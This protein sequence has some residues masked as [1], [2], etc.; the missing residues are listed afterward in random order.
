MRIRVPDAVRT[1]TELDV[2]GPLYRKAEV[3]SGGAQS[4]IFTRI[5]EPTPGRLRA[6]DVQLSGELSAHISVVEN[7]TFDGTNRALLMGQ[8]VHASSVIEFN[9]A[10][11]RVQQLIA[12]LR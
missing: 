12:R 2:P 9:A 10:L 6:V 8:G 7:Y 4:T 1:E 11:D 5:D 3:G